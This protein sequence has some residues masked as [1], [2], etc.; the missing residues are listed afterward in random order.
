MRVWGLPTATHS[1]EQ[2]VGAH[3]V[4]LLP[5]LEPFA[6]THD[7]LHTVSH[8][9]VQLWYTSICRGAAGGT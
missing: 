2:S 8:T 3:T 7:M 5:S 4:S 6:G 9:L 1:S